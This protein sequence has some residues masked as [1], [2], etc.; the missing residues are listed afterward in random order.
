MI[1]MDKVFRIFLTY[2]TFF[3]R[4]CQKINCEVFE[5]DFK[6]SETVELKS[7]VIDELKKE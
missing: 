6:E 1:F 2:L 3:V 7:M 5:M 4:I